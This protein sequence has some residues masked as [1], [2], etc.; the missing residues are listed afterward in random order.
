[1]TVWI[2]TNCGKFLKR[3]NARPP[4]LPPEQPVCRSRQQLERD[5]EQQTG[6]KFG[7]E[8]IKAAY[9]HR[10]YLTYMQSSVQFSC[11]VMS[12]TPWIAAC[13]TSLSITNSQSSPKLMS[14]ES[15][16][17]SSH[18]ILCHP[19]LLPPIPPSIRVFSSESTLCMRWPK[20][21]S[22]YI[23]FLFSWFSLAHVSCLTFRFPS[24]RGIL[25]ILPQCFASVLVSYC[26]FMTIK[27]PASTSAL[28]TVRVPVRAVT[29]DSLQLHEL[30]PPRLLCP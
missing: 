20:Y 30:W 29:S 19:L 17:P 13:Q 16:I 15:V 23:D 25:N 26:P 2:T 5:M 7:K 1:M 4:Y 14:I 12:A 10:S 21:W 6:S 28:F 18:L 3:R 8:Y 24:V 27:L 9:C 22:F 11:S